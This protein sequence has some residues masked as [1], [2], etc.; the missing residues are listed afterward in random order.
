MLCHGSGDNDGFFGGC[1]HI[2]GVGVCPNRWYIDWTTVDGEV[3]DSDQSSLGTVDDVAR[4][5]VGNNPNR[6]AQVAEAVQGTRY[7]CSA[8]VLA[9]DADPSILTDRAAF[10]AAWE[11][12][13]EYQAVADLWEA[14]NKPRNWCMTFG[15]TEGQCCFREDQ[16]TNDTARANLHSTA[17]TIRS[18][19]QGAS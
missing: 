13:A 11:A 17:V 5:Y 8:A 14:R 6:R 2:S 18:Q 7:I 12:T 19:A 16:A 3:F 15:P 1:C 9:I 10:E 4:S